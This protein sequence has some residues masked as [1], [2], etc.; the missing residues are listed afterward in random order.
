MTG[1]PAAV[2]GSNEMR[3]IPLLFLFVASAAAQ[4]APNALPDQVF[5]VPLRTATATMQSMGV[6]IA[7][8]AD[9]AGQLKAI[10][11]GGLEARVQRAPAPLV[12]MII[13]I[14]DAVPGSLVL[15]NH[16]E[17]VVTL[18]RTVGE[19]KSAQYLLSYSRTERDGQTHE[20]FFWRPAYRGQGKL[21]L[22]GCEVGLMVLD[23]NG[24]G[25]FDRRD[26]R[27][28]TTI[29]LDLNNY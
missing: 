7:I 10:I 25:V 20:D 6:G 17:C 23:L 3:R 11:P 14:P 5:R 9:A 8:Q 12:G 24:D 22:P 18:K 2:I 4:D 1:T 26:S 19:L 15:L 28:A 27:S 29:G 21:K 16:Q 13:E